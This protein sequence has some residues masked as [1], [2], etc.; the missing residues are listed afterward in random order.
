MTGSRTGSSVLSLSL[1]LSLKQSQA[2]EFTVRRDCL[3]RADQTRVTA[4]RSCSMQPTRPP[5]SGRSLGPNPSEHCAPPSSR[6]LMKT[7]VADSHLKAGPC[8]RLQ[9][10]DGGTEEPEVYLAQ[11]NLNP[12]LLCSKWW[13]RP[14]VTFPLKARLVKAVVFPVVMYG[15]ESWTVKKAEHRR[16]DAFELWC[17]RRLFRVPWTA[18]RSNQSILKEISPGC[19][20]EGLMLQLK[21]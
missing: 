3:V 9:L 8:H 20:L 4:L 1:P 18:R 21:L 5:G 17:W 15:C 2:S 13:C 16:I 6:L 11:K 19:S 14:P 10:A 7:H 12:E